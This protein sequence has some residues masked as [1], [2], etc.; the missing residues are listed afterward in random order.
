[1]L[2]DLR[3]LQEAGVLRMRVKRDKEEPRLFLY[4]DTRFDP[5]TDCRRTSMP[6]T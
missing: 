1:M 5:A 2:E 4:F 3:V 6:S